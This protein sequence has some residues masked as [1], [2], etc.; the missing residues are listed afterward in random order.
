MLRMQ[1]LLVSFRKLYVL[2][3]FGLHYAL[4]KVAMHPL[5]ARACRFVLVQVV[6][7]YL[8]NPAVFIDGPS[9][10]RRYCAEAGVL[11]V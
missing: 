9:R 3:N 11:P 8:F 6:P 1:F 4:E 2:V 10:A 5:S 7:V